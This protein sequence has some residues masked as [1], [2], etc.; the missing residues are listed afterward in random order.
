MNRRGLVLRLLATLALAFLTFA[1]HSHVGRYRAEGANLAPALGAP[2]WAMQGAVTVSEGV[3][4]I[5]NDDPAGSAGLQFDLPGVSSETY[6]ELSATARTVDVG[7]GRLGWQQARLILGSRDAAGNLRWGLPHEAM[8]VSGSRPWRLY[9]RVLHVPPS[10]SLLLSAHLVNATG[11]F[12][13]RDI[14]IRAAVVKPGFDPAADALKA[15][16]MLLGLAWLVPLARA[17]RTDTRLWLVPAAM[18]AILVATVAPQE[19]RLLVRAAIAT[20]NPGLREAPGV[21]EAGQA[22][23]VQGPNM[24]WVAIDKAGHFAAYAGLAALVLLLAPGW[25]PFLLVLFFA[26]LTEVL[27]LFGA[28]RGPALFDVLVNMAGALTGAL[29]V[30][31]ARHF[32]RDRPAGATAPPP[33]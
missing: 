6:L 31:A 28:D 12:Q 21:V 29:P 23:V 5:R 27:Q 32:L 19:G 16:W 8:R 26:A 22:I 1:L 14:A 15:L 10:P 13:I 7:R 11:Q 17:A 33:V 4:T 9:T 18:V 2:G 24:L 30:I 3:A 25:V 20:L